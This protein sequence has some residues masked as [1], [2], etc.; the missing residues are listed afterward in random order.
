M[1][2]TKSHLAY[3]LMPRS[4]RQRCN[5][6][7]NLV[8]LGSLSFLIPRKQREANL[9]ESDIGAANSYEFH[10][11]QHIIALRHGFLRG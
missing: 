4:E 11:D 3:A 5:L 1:E 6:G 10:L 8:P 9:I 2:R 7:C